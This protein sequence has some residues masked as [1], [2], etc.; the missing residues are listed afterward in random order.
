MTFT[1]SL[2]RFCP[3]PPTRFPSKLKR[4]TIPL[5]AILSLTIIF[6]ALSYNY[7]STLVSHAAVYNQT[8]SDTYSSTS[9]TPPPSPILLNTQIII[10]GVLVAVIIVASMVIL[11]IMNKA[12]N[13][14]QTHTPQKCGLCEP[15]FTY[16]YC[17]LIFSPTSIAKS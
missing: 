14:G 9:P 5:A 16:D 7:S 4:Y 6:I 10:I 12:K 8:Q 3:Q 15:I 13:K 2:R 1:K 11:V 17:F